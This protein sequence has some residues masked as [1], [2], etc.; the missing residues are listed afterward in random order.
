MAGN[1]VYTLWIGA[2]DLGIGGFLNGMN[3]ENTTLSSLFDCNW[4]IFNEI[5]KTGGR[6]FVVFGRPP[7]QL[8]TMYVPELVDIN[9]GS[10]WRPSSSHGILDDN[11]KMT[12]YAPRVSTRC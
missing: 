10:G 7:L 5:F 12:E 1:K 9:E 4:A 11:G 2:N 8:A 3:H 6:Q